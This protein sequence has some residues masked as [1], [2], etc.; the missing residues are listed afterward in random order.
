M[1]LENSQKNTKYRMKRNDYGNSR[2]NF[3][4]YYLQDKKN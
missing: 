3:R 4:K 2:D 1:S